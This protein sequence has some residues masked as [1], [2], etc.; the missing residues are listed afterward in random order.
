[1]YRG[2]KCDREFTGASGIRKYADMLKSSI[3]LDSAVIILMIDCLLVVG[4]AP[5]YFSNPLDLSFISPSY[6]TQPMSLQGNSPQSEYPIPS[7]A[8]SSTV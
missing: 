3:P 6:L 4:S 1:M 2:L 7:A 5:C 8:L